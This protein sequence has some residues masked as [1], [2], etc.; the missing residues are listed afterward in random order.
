MAGEIAQQVDEVAR[1]PEDAPAADLAPA[2]AFVI[3]PGE[4]WGLAEA[5]DD[6]ALLRVSVG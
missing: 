1:L 6:L 2:D 5:S 3:P 4:P